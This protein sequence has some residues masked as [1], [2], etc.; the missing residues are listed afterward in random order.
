MAYI[1]KIAEQNGFEVTVVDENIGD[2]IP[3]NLLSNYDLIG[4]TLSSP[5]FLYNPNLLPQLT[6]KKAPHA[7]IIAGGHHPT[8]CPEEV[9]HTGVN[10]VIRGECEQIFSLF[11]QYFFN[12]EKIFRLPGISY[13]DSNQTV[14]NN[15]LPPLQENLDLIP[16]PNRSS[17]RYSKYLPMSLIASRGCP[18]Q[19]SYCASA[20]FWQHRIRYRSVPNIIA[21]IDSIITLY[22]YSLLK[23]QDSVFS[24]QK[25]RTT[26]LL[27]AM[28]AN[29]YDFQWIC[30]TRVDCLDLETIQL[31]RQAGCK[32]IMIGLESGSQQILDKNKRHLKI[33]QIINSC[34]QIMQAG[35]GL[36]VSVI[37]GLPGETKQTAEETITLLKQIHP[38]VTFLNLAT[39]YPGCALEKNPIAI[40]NNN[41][42]QTY[43]GHGICGKILLPDGMTAKQYRKIAEYMQREIHLINRINWV[44][45]KTN[46][47]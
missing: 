41:W 6:R 2:L 37:F 32:G 9:L 40:H 13:L 30:E 18:F 17:F 11:L 42:L 8:F 29:K 34:N 20:V 47:I 15:P 7:I 46:D 27:H 45:G 14:C 38:N 24:L 31:M 39:I 25:D 28:I 23:F 22:P 10:F 43:S 19:C 33:Q 4:V 16:F 44:H 3:W 1:I 12:P 5:A 21:E 26:A 35:I 36:R